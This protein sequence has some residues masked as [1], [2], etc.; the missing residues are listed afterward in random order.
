MK[1][2]YEVLG[3]SQNATKSEILKARTTAMKNRIFRL[4]DIH[5]AEKQLLNPIQ[6]LAADFI[7]P[8]RIKAS[9]IL[10][11]QSECDE[12][13]DIQSIDENIFNSLGPTH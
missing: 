13:T 4:P 2:P 1:N 12:T 6:R 10:W 7:Y 5:M 9:R 11:I 3:V 8:T